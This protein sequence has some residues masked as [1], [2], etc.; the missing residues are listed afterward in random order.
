MGLARIEIEVPKEVLKYINSKDKD[1]QKKIRELMV[2]NLVKEEKISFGKGAELLGIDKVT[3][4]TD[5][6]KL[7][8]PY[9]DQ[10]V[11]EVL[12]ELEQIR[13]SGGGIN[14]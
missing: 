10:D 7:G 3:F 1:F 4:I 6:G 9:F 14:Q 2:Y 5:L 12:K 8:I 11:E 13:E